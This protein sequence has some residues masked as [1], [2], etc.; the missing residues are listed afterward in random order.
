[1]FSMNP[2]F[3]AQVGN[4]PFRRLVVGRVLA[5]GRICGLPI[6]DTADWQSALR[7]LG[8]W[9]PCAILESWRLSMREGGMTQKAGEN[10]SL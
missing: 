5:P 3:V 8:S 1:M 9:S 2:F 10:Q 4:L 7:L 6:R